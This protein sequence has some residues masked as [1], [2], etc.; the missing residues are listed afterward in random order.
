MDPVVLELIRVFTAPDGSGGNAL[1]VFL[2]GPAF[3][4]QRRQSIAAELGFAETVFVD[5]PVDGVI[6]IFTP[7]A[8]LAFAGHPT[9]GTAWLLGRY[10]RPTSVLRPPAGDVPTWPD[11][12]L[13]WI[14]ARAAWVHPIVV[15]RLPTP[16]DVEALVGPPAGESSYYP[17]AWID[18]SAGT[19]R[20]RY[21]FEGAG[22][23]E[24]EATGA[25]AVLMG[26]RLGRP[27]EIHQGR[28]SVLHVRPGPDGTV[29]VGGRCVFVESRPYP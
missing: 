10:G 3:E 28:G 7:G 6:R 25:A 1:G 26:E 18:E 20:S 23:T 15:D 5:D 4:P 11:G 8:E 12:E 29:E 21:F 24:D 13:T 16:A 2:D 19:L 14:R 9:I 22:I 17:W 27:L